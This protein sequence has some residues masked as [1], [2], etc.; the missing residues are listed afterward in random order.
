MQETA[1]FLAGLLRLVE[2]TQGRA[3]TVRERLEER[4]LA[5]ARGSVERFMERIALRRG[6]GWC[7]I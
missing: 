6:Q 4:A 3:A 5:N 7:V 1:S 2:T